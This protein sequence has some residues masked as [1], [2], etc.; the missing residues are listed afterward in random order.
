MDFKERLANLMSDIGEKSDGFGIGE[1]GSVPE[2]SPEA[3]VEAQ[4]L[5]PRRV[6]D[7]PEGRKLACGHTVYYKTDIMSANLGSSCFNCYDRMS[8][9]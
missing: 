9:V 6:A 1:A 7:Y 5:Q 3:E 8:D 4:Q 2:T